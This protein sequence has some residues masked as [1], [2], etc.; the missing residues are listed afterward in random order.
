MSISLIYLGQSQIYLELSR[1]YVYDIHDDNSQATIDCHPSMCSILSDESITDYDDGYSTHSSDDVEHQQLST[2]VS[3]SLPLC[4][5]FQSSIWP[6]RRLIQQSTFFNP[7]K[8][9][10]QQMMNHNPVFFR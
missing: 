1:T 10:I 9:T 4:H 7:F 3:K 2:S 5:S 8:K 6:I